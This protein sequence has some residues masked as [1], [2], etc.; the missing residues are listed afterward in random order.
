MKQVQVELTLNSLEYGTLKMTV[1]ER[2]E[3][4]KMRLSTTTKSQKIRSYSQ[5][6]K[7]LEKL[8]HTLEEYHELF[9]QPESAEKV[10]LN[11]FPDEPNLGSAQRREFLAAHV[12][13]DGVLQVSKS[14]GQKM[15]FQGLAREPEREKGEVS[16]RLT[17]KGH[18]VAQGLVEKDIK[19]GEARRRGQIQ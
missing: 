16:F 4:A 1:S 7:N 8:L 15:M 13:H 9:F 10:N 5:E 11:G 19:M 17:K 3:V 6:V 14:V 18:E 2:L 12:Y